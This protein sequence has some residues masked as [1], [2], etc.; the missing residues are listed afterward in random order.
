MLINTLYHVE[1]LWHTQEKEKSTEIVHTIELCL[2]S[3]SFTDMHLYSPSPFESL[4]AVNKFDL[5]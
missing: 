1:I 4:M 5:K 2:I 3:K